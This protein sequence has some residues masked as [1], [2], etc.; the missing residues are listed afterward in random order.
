MARYDLERRI[1]FRSGCDDS[2]LATVSDRDAERVSEDGEP[3]RG[4][5]WFISRSSIGSLLRMKERCRVNED[6]P[7]MTL[8]RRPSGDEGY[9]GDVGEMDN[10]VIVVVV[11]SVLEKMGLGEVGGERYGSD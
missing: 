5:G 11:I 3:G 8:S 9:E 4:S 2:P 7:P 6:G 1:E 10:S